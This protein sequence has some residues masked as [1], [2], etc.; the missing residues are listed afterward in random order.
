MQARKR[1]DQPRFMIGIHEEL[2]DVGVDQGN[3]TAALP[4]A[5]GWRLLKFPIETVPLCDF[6]ELDRRCP[7]RRENVGA[8]HGVA[9]QRLE[10]P[11]LN[12]LYASAAPTLPGGDANARLNA[13]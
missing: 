12:A 9:S 8:G 13:A 11:S 1:V 2:D 5:L 6:A 10:M 4:S 7:V 3:Q